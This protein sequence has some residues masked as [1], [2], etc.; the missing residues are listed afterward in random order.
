MESAAHIY[1]SALPWL[2]KNSA[3]YASVTSG[4]V[5]RDAIKGGKSDWDAIVWERT[6]G[7]QFNCL[8]VSPDGR[9]IACGAVNGSIYSW[10]AQSG[11][12]LSS[13]PRHSQNATCVA[14]SPDSRQIVSGSSDCTLRRWDAETGEAV[15]ESLRGHT[16]WVRAVAYSPDGRC[17]SLG[18]SRSGA[19]PKLGQGAQTRH[20]WAKRICVE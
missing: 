18:T 15:G 9:S 14:Y 5:L 11:S 2:P 10:N 13:P 17:I 7:G 8:A 16:D 12:P 1:L 6:V 20:R 3:V 19:L 4:F